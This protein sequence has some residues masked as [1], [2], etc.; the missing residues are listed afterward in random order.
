MR[1]AAVGFLYHAAS[2]QVLL[3]HHDAGAVQYHE[4]WAGFGGPDKPEDGADPAATWRRAMH[5]ELGIEL[6]PEQVK[7]LRQYIN[8][9]VGLPRYVFYVVWPS[10][11]KRFTLN[12]GDGYAWIPL[13][14]AIVLPDLMDLA[15]GDLLFLRDA[16]GY[17]P[18]PAEDDGAVTLQ[19]ELYLVA[20]ELRGAAT[21][22][23]AFAANVYEAERA[24][25]AMALAARIAA[26]ADDA[27]EDQIKRIFGADD[28]KRVSPAVGVDNLVFNER[29]EVLL[30][31]R[32]DNDHWCMPGGFAEIGQTPAEAVLKELWEEA[33][34][35]GETERLLGVFDGR[36]WGSRSRFHMI[37]LVY[38]V[39]CADL[40]PVPGVE[41]LEARFFPP[42]AL[43]EPMHA[44]HD[45]RLPLC[46]ELAR[47][48]QTYTDPATTT[49][50]TDLPMHQRPSQ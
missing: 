42:D 16:V 30:V 49:A 22:W 21:A 32:R 33:G 1:Y 7:P 15:R 25:Q 3:H 20:D 19:Q 13:D 45:R 5:D 46:I 41:M 36:L 28:W 9:D 38:L 14:E 10:L 40:T 43:P 35:R 29:G 39:R 26:L 11:D 23:K 4:C 12:E 37:H 18:G 48:G 47:N 31:R 34:L 6:T 50:A 2:R 44:G 8:P 24:D 27:P 17:R